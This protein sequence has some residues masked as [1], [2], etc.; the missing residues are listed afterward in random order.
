MRKKHYY[1]NFIKEFKI[2][3][4]FDELIGFV[5]HL[6]DR[7]WNTYCIYVNKFGHHNDHDDTPSY[8]PPVRFQ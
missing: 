1:I 5:M 2:K 8:Q 7:V 6:A 4:L 3:I